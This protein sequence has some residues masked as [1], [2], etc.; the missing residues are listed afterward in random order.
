M[1]VVELLLY[2]MIRTRALDESE[3]SVTIMGCK[4]EKR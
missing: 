2:E 3:G 1:Y 4:L